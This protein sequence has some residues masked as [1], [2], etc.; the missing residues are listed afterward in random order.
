MNNLAIASNNNHSCKDRTNTKQL[1][2]KSS[3][4][5]LTP[6]TTS[7]RTILYSCFQIRQPYK[8]V[9]C[10]QKKKNIPVWEAKTV[11]WKWDGL[12]KINKLFI[13]I[14]WEVTQHQH[15]L[16]LCCDPVFWKE[17]KNLKNWVNYY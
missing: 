6:N 12:K 5:M 16:K 11:T 10:K 8:N 9:F 3:D 17:K 1:M 7:E 13:Q 14:F 4:K 15:P 2:L